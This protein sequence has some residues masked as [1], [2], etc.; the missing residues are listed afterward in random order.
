MLSKEGK[1]WKVVANIQIT[2]EDQGRERSELNVII[3]L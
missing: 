3:K 2:A 1:G